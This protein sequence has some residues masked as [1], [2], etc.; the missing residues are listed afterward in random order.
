MKGLSQAK[1]QSNLDK[2]GFLDLLA[3][4]SREGVQSVFVTDL[5]EIS[6]TLVYLAALFVEKIQNN[7]VAKDR[8]ASGALSA[9]VVP[10]EVVIFDKIYSIDIKMSDY[11]KFVDEGV[12]GWADEKG[13]GSP[14]QFKNAYVSKKMMEAIRKW[15]ICEGLKGKGRENT[16]NVGPRDR[17]R[18]AIS[19]TSQ[20]TAYAISYSIKKK[21]L[22]P[23]HFLSSAKNEMTQIIQKELGLAL[24]V[25]IINII[26]NGN[27]N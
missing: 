23:S 14:Y 8:I 5:N 22:R 24:K 15:V 1:R 12:K 10:T 19:D 18:N 25:D 13:G 17:K 4:G 9:S 26:T 21:G 27:S 20:A 7:L 2:T 3:E 11:Y 16:R 6:D